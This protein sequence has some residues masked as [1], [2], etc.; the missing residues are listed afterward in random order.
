MSS[1]ARVF[2]NGWKWH[3]RLARMDIAT[4]LGPGTIA[5]WSTFSHRSAISCGRD[6]CRSCYTQ[7]GAVVAD[8][9]VV[10]AFIVDVVVVLII[11]VCLVSVLVCSTAV[12][13]SALL[14]PRPCVFNLARRRW[15]MGT[16]HHGGHVKHYSQKKRIYSARS[17]GNPILSSI[18]DTLLLPIFCPPGRHTG[19]EVNGNLEKKRGASYHG[20][21]AQV[22]MTYSHGTCS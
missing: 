10:I 20:T 12:C 9:N 3:R 11:V 7:H 8:V 2:G 6:R 18:V 21:S 17:W 16:P 22:N 15:Y 4:T 1:D 13:P 19:N 14:P 5:C